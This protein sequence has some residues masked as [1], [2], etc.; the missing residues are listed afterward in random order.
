MLVDVRADRMSKPNAVRDVG[1]VGVECPRER[2]HAQQTCSE[3]NIG[4]QFF[5]RKALRAS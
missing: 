2:S 5:F 4:A 3:A 1:R